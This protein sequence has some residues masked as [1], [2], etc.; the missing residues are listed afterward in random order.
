MSTID[1]LGSLLNDSDIEADARPARP[2]PAEQR[3]NCQRCGG[4]GRYVGHMTFPGRV[5][6]SEHVNGKCFCCDGRG[7][8]RKPY[9]VAMADK[10]AAKIK[11]EDGVRRAQMSRVEAFDK[12]QPGL[13]AWMRQ[14]E[15]SQ[16]ILDMAALV[17]SPRGL[18][19][20]QLAAVLSTKAKSD[21]R[22]AARKAERAQA[23]AQTKP[24][25]DAIA[26]MFDKARETMKKPMYR[27]AGLVLYVAPPTS[28]NAGAIYVK[29]SDRGDYLGKVVNG[30]LRIAYGVK[31]TEQ[32]KAAFAEIAADPAG[33]AKRHGLETGSCCCC[34]RRLTD[35][36][37][38]AAGIGPDCAEGWGF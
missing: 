18:S 19:E 25:V 32:D 12:A 15:W 24:V 13:L 6:H 27:A 23:A 37:S 22:N 2:V 10:Q 35:P 26:A 16:F 5:I 38:V 7:W 14:Q 11:R 3:F 9:A 17:D 21:A 30:E 31:L 29:R 4:S 34:G 1:I 8:F 28:V 20:R 33:A 36:A